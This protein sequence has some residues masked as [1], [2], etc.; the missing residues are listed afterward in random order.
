MSTSRFII[1]HLL[2][3]YQD[4][5][6]YTDNDAPIST[7]NFPFSL[8]PAK[9]SQWV[10]FYINSFSFRHNLHILNMNQMSSTLYVFWKI[11]LHKLWESLPNGEILNS[12]RVIK[13]YVKRYVTLI[14][15]WKCRLFTTFV[16][17]GRVF[18]S[19]LLTKS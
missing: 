1:S 12:L 17:S 18:S 13:R 11:L 4:L 15:F 6:L 14:L 10:Y 5:H 8:V 16:H 19:L 2:I 9:F 7:E 3:S